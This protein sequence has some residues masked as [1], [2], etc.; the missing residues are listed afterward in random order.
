RS[1]MGMHIL[2]A[3]RKVSDNVVN[4]IN[5]FLPCGFCSQSNDPLADCALLMKETSRKIQ[6]ESKCPRQD[7]FQYGS[8]S[9]GSDIRPCRNV[10]VVCQLCIHQNRD[11]DWLPALWRYNFEAHLNLAHPEYAHP[12]KLIGLPLPD[13]I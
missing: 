4:P 12:G 6:W 2:R 10:P 8:A 1:H 13:T 11:T 7:T 9:Q 3:A 5:G